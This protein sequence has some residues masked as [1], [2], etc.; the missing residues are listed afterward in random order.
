MH[1]SVR[2]KDPESEIEFEFE[3]T[4]ETSRVDLDVLTIKL[5]I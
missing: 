4:S 5:K 1:D 2:L 3:M